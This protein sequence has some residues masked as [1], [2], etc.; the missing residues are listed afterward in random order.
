MRTT[1]LAALVCAVAV[2]AVATSPASAGAE[3][4]CNGTFTDTTL[5][6]GVVVNPGD[7]CDLENVTVNGGLTVNGGGIGVVL[8]VNNSNINGGWSITGIVFLNG[9]PANGFNG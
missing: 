4:E 7:F 8:S 6:G 9:V 3:S 5:N 2:A 1:F